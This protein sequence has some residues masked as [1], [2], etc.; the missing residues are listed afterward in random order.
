MEPIIRNI[1][2]TKTVG[3]ST[4]FVS[5]ITPDA[6]NFKLIPPLWG[7]FMARHH[8]ITG[9]SSALNYG[10]VICLDEH[11]KKTHPDEMLYFAGA[12]I[13]SSATPPRGMMTLII[14]PGDYAIFVHR[15]P[16]EEIRRTLDH[17]Y[18]SWLP[19][20]GRTLRDAPHLEI[21]D[22]RFKLGSPDSEFE[23][24]VPV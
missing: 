15:G 23:I 20:S 12:P 5:G 1:L 19:Q 2:K 24:A 6:N 21:Y 8:E 7:K 4:R 11:D 10:V 18:G 14:P 22:E 13:E 9:R 17:I 3:L 16:V